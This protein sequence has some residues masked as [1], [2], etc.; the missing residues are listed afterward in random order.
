MSQP[1]DPTPTTGVPP[2][3]ACVNFQEI[4]GGIAAGRAL[5]SALRSILNELDERLIR[6]EDATSG[7]GTPVDRLDS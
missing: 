6:I 1:P 2:A 4:W 3:P 5:I 7:F